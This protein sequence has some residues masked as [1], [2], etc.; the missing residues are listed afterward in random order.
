[1]Q[2]AGPG[3]AGPRLSVAA[4]VGAVPTT[5]EAGLAAIRAA[6]GGTMTATQGTLQDATCGAVPYEA[7]AVDLNG[8][9]Q[10]EVMTKE[11]GGCFGMAGVRMNI[12][13]QGRNGRWVPRFGFP[14]MPMV[15]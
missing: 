1:M 9:G 3:L 6:T 11:H 14:G 8:D 12:Y 2:D 10:P 5:D 15:Q 13:I 7:E 4:Q